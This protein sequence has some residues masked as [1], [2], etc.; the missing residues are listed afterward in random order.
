MGLGMFLNIGFSHEYWNREYGFD[1]GRGT[2]F[3]PAVKYEQQCRMED[4]LFRRYGKYGFLDGIK[5]MGTQSKPTLAVEPFGHRFVPAMFGAGVEYKCDQAPWAVHRDLSDGEVRALEPM[6]VDRFHK[7]PLVRE[8]ISQCDLLKKRGVVCSAQ[9]IMGSA[10][11]T[12][13]YLRGMDMFY[14]FYERPDVIRRLIE[15]ITDV[16]LTAYG[17]FAEYDGFL[18]EMGVGNCAVAMLSPDIYERFF[19]PADMRIMERARELGVPYHIHQDS[20]VDAF[21]PSYRA[22]DYLHGL[23]VG[24]DTD[25]GLF[26]ETFPNLK[27]NV[28][29]YTATLQRMTADELYKWLIG[30]AGKAKP[31]DKVGFSAY[32][33]D[34]GVPEGNAVALCEAYKYL[35]EM[36]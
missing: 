28:F 5:T 32:D 21:F 25:M 19:R 10:V 24:D 27:L 34:G 22:F 20:R 6:T 12:I 16:L 7:N 35:K 23:D 11:N 1:F 13:I 17:Y 31:F 29:V 8:I 4:I 36:E 30:I 26:R 18:N 3:D 33:I 9:Q 14:D 2:Y 15:R